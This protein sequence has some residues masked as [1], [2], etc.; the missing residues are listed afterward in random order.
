MLEADGKGAV[1][2]GGKRRRGAARAYGSSPLLLTMAVVMP[3]A[4]L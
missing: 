1:A 4:D 2:G 3:V